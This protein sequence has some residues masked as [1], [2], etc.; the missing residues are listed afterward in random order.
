M[1]TTVDF[2]FRMFLWSIVELIGNISFSFAAHMDRL[3]Q[4]SLHSELCAIPVM[5]VASGLTLIIGSHTGFHRYPNIEA[6][7]E[8]ILAWNQLDEMVKRDWAELDVRF[9]VKLV[10]SAGI[11]AEQEEEE[12][13][14]ETPTTT[15]NVSASL[16]ASCFGRIRDDP[17][18]DSGGHVLAAYNTSVFRANPTRYL[19]D[20]W[21]NVSQ[22]YTLAVDARDKQGA[23][24]FNWTES[25][26]P[27]WQTT[28][29]CT[30]ASGLCLA[31][32]H[33]LA[34]GFRVSGTCGL[35]L[36]F[37]YIETTC[38]GNYD[39]DVGKVFL[40]FPLELRLD[41]DPYVALGRRSHGEFAFGFSPPGLWQPLGIALFVLGCVLMVSCYWILPLVPN[42]DQQD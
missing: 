19:A 38:G 32:S 10:N 9:S 31:V 16:C 15:R 6:H 34:I 25:L 27:F 30:Q 13:E 20:S 17:T 40:R 12:E 41:E 33:N 35:A 11:F 3:D 24:V 42:L 7:A 1:K 2:F 23:Q 29:Y 8:S 4:L 14:E 21:F 37:S 39:D 26:S 18:F 36:P 28:S 22:L 5:L